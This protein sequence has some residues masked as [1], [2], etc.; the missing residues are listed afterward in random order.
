MKREIIIVVNFLNI[1]IQQRCVLTIEKD[2]EQYYLT[3]ST[4]YE[5]VYEEKF[6]KKEDALISALKYINLYNL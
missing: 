3:C 1:D 4:K 2:E 6:E 5:L